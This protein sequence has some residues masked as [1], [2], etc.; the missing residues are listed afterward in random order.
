MAIGAA[1]QVSYRD[2]Y[3]DNA[4]AVSF[5]HQMVADGLRYRR[6]TTPDAVIA[7]GAAGSAA[8]FSD[9][10]SVD[11]LG[12]SDA[13]IAHEPPRSPVFTPGHDKY[14]FEYSLGRLKPDL[15]APTLPFAQVAGYK[16]AGPL[17][18]FEQVRV[19]TTKV[20]LPVLLRH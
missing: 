12:K 3:D 15:V 5:D 2:W 4:Q 8:Y 13:H 11:M 6:A 10:R 17:K 20:D 18:Y 14:D 16:L 9:R 19:G 1:N 7:F